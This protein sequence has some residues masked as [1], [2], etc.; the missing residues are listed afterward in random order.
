MSSRI[1]LQLYLRQD[2]KTQMYE[3][4]ENIWKLSYNGIT[5]QHWRFYYMNMEMTMWGGVLDSWK[6]E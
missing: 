1:L 4:Y 2:P 6:C 3:E 5:I